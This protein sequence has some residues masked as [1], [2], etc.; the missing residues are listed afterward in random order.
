MINDDTEI[1]FHESPIALWAAM[2]V[3]TIIITRAVTAGNTVVISLVVVLTVGVFVVSLL[4]AVVFASRRLLR[5]R[6]SFVSKLII[7]AEVVMLTLGI[8]VVTRLIWVNR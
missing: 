8:L 1:L 6:F 4:F 2:I 3:R 7:V 5:V